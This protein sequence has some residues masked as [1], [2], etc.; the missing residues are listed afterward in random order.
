MS[1][2]ERQ[3]F[4]ERKFEEDRRQR[5]LDREAKERESQKDRELPWKIES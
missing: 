3:F 1:A 4:R 2:E 5:E